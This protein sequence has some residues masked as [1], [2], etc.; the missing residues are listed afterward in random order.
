[1]P[2]MS[3]QYPQGRRNVSGPEIGYP[4][5]R[6]AQA[7]RPYAASSDPSLLRREYSGGGEQYEQDNSEDDVDYSDQDEGVHVDVAPY[8]QNYVTG[9]P[10]VGRPRNSRR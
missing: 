2:Q 6:G 5:L 8:G 10:G 3:I 4:S 7:A 1:M 9:P